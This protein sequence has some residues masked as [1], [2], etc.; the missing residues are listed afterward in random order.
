MKKL[1]VIALCALLALGGCATQRQAAGDYF[2]DAAITTKVKKAIYD[3]PALKVT[4]ISVRTDDHV[5]YL[6]GTVKTRGAAV[7]AA[8]V[9]RKVDGV[10][11]V[12]S[13]LKVER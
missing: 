13:D 2:D 10:K 8:Q 9:A 4:Q 5:V 12:K 7:K 11:A 6:T 1:H 3:E